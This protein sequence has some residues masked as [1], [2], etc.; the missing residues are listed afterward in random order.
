VQ[1]QIKLLIQKVATAKGYRIV[2][3]EQAEQAVPMWERVRR[4]LD[5]EPQMIFDVGANEGQTA[6][7]LSRHFASAI[8]HS[9]EPDPTTYERLVQNLSSGK[10]VV[11]HNFALGDETTSGSLK[12]TK[13]SVGNSLLPLEENL[14]LG[15]WTIGLDQIPV[16]VRR[17]DEFCAESGIS[18]I[19]ILKTDTQGAEVAVLTGAGDMLHP[20]SIKVV[21]CEVIF[22]PL[23]KGQSE[24]EDIHSYLIQ[25]DYSLVGFFNE[26]RN[27]RQQIGWADAV[28]A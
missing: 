10:K 9:F 27:E 24:F 5:A 28:Y 17:L 8:L 18:H 4:C 19:D 26:V 2:K 23:Y 22:R 13:L 25:R 21:Q 15:D 3:A 7:A 1:D 11:T 12:R 6:D 14:G 16:S 20:H